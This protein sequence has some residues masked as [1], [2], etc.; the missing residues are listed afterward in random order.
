MQRL[1]ISLTFAGALVCVAAMACVACADTIYESATLGPT[2]ATVGSGVDDLQYLGVRF[3]LAS[4]AT[5]RSIGGHFF[6]GGQIFGA[7]V[8]LSSI[9]DFPDTTDLSSADVLAHT[10][11]TV[12]AHSAEVS[13][14]IGPITLAPGFYALIFGAG[15]FGATGVGAA[16]NDNTDIGSPSYFFWNPA[17]NP[18]YIA[19]RFSGT[20]FFLNSQAVD[21]PLP[22]V[23]WGGAAL[24]GG[25]GFAR[26]LRR[27]QPD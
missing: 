9:S 16:P 13:A 21:A 3:Q 5:A 11:I 8:Q 23:A 6:G 18:G 14:N 1:K 12:P 25:L 27:P 19:G 10:L 22:A 4:T 7:I 2:D 20:R 24:L 26:R 15:R 17:L